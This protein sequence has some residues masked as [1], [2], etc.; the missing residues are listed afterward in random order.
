VYD[1]DTSE[2]MLA[3][4]RRRDAPVEY[5]VGDALA[6]PFPDEHFGVAVC[7]QVYEYVEDIAA[8]LT[9]ARR[10]L[11]AGGRLLVLDTDWDSIVWLLLPPQSLP[12]CA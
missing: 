11:R 5:G 9:E 12:V 1:I 6:L 10:V 7:T 8:A 3:R 2:T 4:A